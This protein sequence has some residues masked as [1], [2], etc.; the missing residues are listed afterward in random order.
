MKKYSFIFRY[1]QLK[2]SS[3][4]SDIYLISVLHFSKFFE[5]TSIVSTLRTYYSISK[6]KNSICKMNCLNLQLK[7]RL[8]PFSCIYFL[9]GVDNSTLSH[10]STSGDLLNISPIQNR[11]KWKTVYIVF[12]MG[13]H[14][15]V[16]YMK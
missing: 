5:D 3:T 16:H 6:G 4:M 13:R 2:Y 14:E 9:T 15:P 10:L 7:K 12:V 1:S 11:K 8:L